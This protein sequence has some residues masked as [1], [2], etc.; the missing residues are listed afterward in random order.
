MGRGERAAG[1]ETAGVL[2]APGPTLSGSSSSS[3]GRGQGREI[4]AASTS[5]PLRAAQPGDRRRSRSMRGARDGRPGGGDSSGSALLASGT[6]C[7]RC[8]CASL[9]APVPGAAAASD[10]RPRP[11][12]SRPPMGPGPAPCVTARRPRPA[13]QVLVGS[14]SPQR[15]L[16]PVRARAPGGFLGPSGPHAPSYKAEG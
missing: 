1:R 11:A 14:G 3:A 8:R 6:C 4:A 9:P 10:A 12:L 7:R 2:E 5:R 16:G 13:P 15:A